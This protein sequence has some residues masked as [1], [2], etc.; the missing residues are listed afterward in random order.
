MLYYFFFIFMILSLIIFSRSSCCGSTG[1]AATLELWD[2]GLIA[3]LVQWVK[4]SH[5]P[6]MQCRSQL[7]LR[8]DPWPRNSICRRV[9]KI[10]II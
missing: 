2:A 8:S 6:Q 4:G 5:E 10:I 9:T 7:W 3:R 1:S